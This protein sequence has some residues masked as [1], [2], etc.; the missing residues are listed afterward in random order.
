[1]RSA[2]LFGCSCCKIFS[3][4]ELILLD[5]DETTVKEWLEAHEH[6]SEDGSRS[7]KFVD[8]KHDDI[9]MQRASAEGKHDIGAPTADVFV[10]QQPKP[11]PPPTRRP[12]PSRDRR[13]S[14]SCPAPHM[15]FVD[16]TSAPVAP[17]LPVIQ[18]SIW[19]LNA[20][21]VP[22]VLFE[23]PEE[24]EHDHEHEA[25]T[26]PHSEVDSSVVGGRHGTQKQEGSFVNE[27]AEGEA[28]SKDDT[29]T[30]KP[31]RHRPRRKKTV[32]CPTHMLFHEGN[33][34][35]SHNYYFG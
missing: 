2:F 20:Q 21:P 27:A 30:T 31:R 13:R 18:P 7:D 1:M 34:H 35:V 11:T 28:A 6:G 22:R 14:T 26:P 5:T 24:H 19:E 12:R 4:E 32:S 3:Q 29:A 17:E 23:I 15:L 25:E 33:K 8:D 16:G 10:A 9:E